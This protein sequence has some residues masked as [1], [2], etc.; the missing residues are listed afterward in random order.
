MLRNGIQKLLQPKKVAVIQV[1]VLGEG[2]YT[3]S[4]ALF[5]NKAGAFV[6]ESV[7]EPSSTLAL[8]KEFTPGL[9]YLLHVFGKGIIEKENAIGPHE[10]AAPTLGK[11]ED[12]LVFQSVETERYAYTSFTRKET[13]DSLLVMLKAQSILPVELVLGSGFLVR[14]ASLQRPTAGSDVSLGYGYRLLLQGESWRLGKDASEAPAQFSFLG[15]EIAI[16]SLRLYLIATLF[17]VN[18]QVV[19]PHLQPEVVLYNRAKY[20]TQQKVKVASIAL[21]LFTFVVLLV[22]SFLFSGI[23]EQQVRL[24]SEL[25]Q[26]RQQLA[27][28]DSLKRSLTQLEQNIPGIKGSVKFQPSYVF[29]RVGSTLPAS[30]VLQS[31]DMN[32]ISGKIRDGEEVKVKSGIFLISGTTRSSGDISA[33]IE[34]LKREAWV[35]EVELVSLLNVEQQNQFVVRIQLK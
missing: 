13:I 21:L 34:A 10:Q 19:E 14:Y 11:D 1:Q 6:A 18:G 12:G 22:N 4:A 28:L 31:A 8:S 27:V 16:A 23:S 20:R 29:D 30:V 33:W 2:D 32:P 35:T 25:Q 5:S 3:F 15:E 24:S 9:P 17:I 26:N 7:A